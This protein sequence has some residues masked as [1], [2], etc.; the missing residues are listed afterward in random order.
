MWLKL[1]RAGTQL[2]YFDGITVA[3][4]VHSNATNN[5]GGDFLFSPARLNNYNIRKKYVFPHLSSL[6]IIN[7][8]YEYFFIKLFIRFKLN[9]KSNASFFYFVTRYIN[10]FWLISRLCRI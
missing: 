7:E 10:P 6:V 9:K 1:T 8:K 3:Y 4:R 5:I 2:Y